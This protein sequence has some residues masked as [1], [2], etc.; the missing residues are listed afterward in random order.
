MKTFMYSFKKGSIFGRKSRC[1]PEKEQPI[2]CT[3]FSQNVCNL[4]WIFSMA[5]LITFTKHIFKYYVQFHQTGFF[6]SCCLRVSGGLVAS[7][8]SFPPP[9]G[10]AWP[11]GKAPPVQSRAVPPPLSASASAKR[12]GGGRLERHQ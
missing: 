9:R 2:T 4:A 6:G 7:P 11:A 5:F 8:K 3:I 12:V 1:L 10:E